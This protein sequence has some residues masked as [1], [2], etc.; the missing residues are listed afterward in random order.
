MHSGRDAKTTFIREQEDNLRIEQILYSS[1][2]K[3][4]EGE[5][6]K[7]TMY[8]KTSAAS[9]TIYASI[10]AAYAAMYA[11]T[12]APWDAKDELRFKGKK[13]LRASLIALTNSVTNT[14]IILTCQQ[15]RQAFQ[16]Q[17]T[18]AFGRQEGSF[19]W[20]E[21]EISVVVWYATFEFLSNMS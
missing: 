10:D 6:F 7:A 11:K 1:T 21:I 9:S 12:G 19:P 18:T 5:A 16:P 3:V 8:A 2:L 17:L 15:D 13:N 20:T 4:F 14:N